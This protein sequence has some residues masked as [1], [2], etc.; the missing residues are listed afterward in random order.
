M[1]SVDELSVRVA[2][3]SCIDGCRAWV[4]YPSERVAMEGVARKL[5]IGSA[6]TRASGSVRRKSMGEAGQCD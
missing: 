2:R 6:E 4:D 3:A 5:A 1:K